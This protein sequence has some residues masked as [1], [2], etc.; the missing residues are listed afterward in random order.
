MT[1][2]YFLHLYSTPIFMNFIRLLFEK[3][4]IHTKGPCSDSSNS[5][6]LWVY[7][8]YV[9]LVRLVTEVVFYRTLLWPC[10]ISSFI[11]DTWIVIELS[12]LLLIYAFLRIW[13]EKMVHYIICS[14]GNQMHSLCCVRALYLTHIGCKLLQSKNDHFK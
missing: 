12:C 14:M 3:H 8:V 4:F 2:L 1:Y 10:L 6:I 5:K 7:I 13:C 9:I 11:H